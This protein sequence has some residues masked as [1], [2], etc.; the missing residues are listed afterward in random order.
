MRKPR[1][2]QAR[3]THKPPRRAAART[4]AQAEAIRRAVTASATE[5]LRALAPDESIPKVL[6]RIGRSADVSRVVVF[7]NS[8]AANGGVA[9][10]LCYEWDAA[11]VRPRK[12]GASSP[13]QMPLWDPEELIPLLTQGEPIRLVARQV[14]KPLRAMMQS[15]GVKS[16]LLVPIFVDTKWWG[17]ICFD[18]CRRERQWTAAE[19]DTLRTLAE[20]IGAAIARARD[21]RHLAD[22]SRVVEN[23]PVILFRIAAQSPYPLLYLSQNVSRFG[24]R[25]AEL[26]ASPCRYLDLFHPDDAPAMS[27]DIRRIL[28][29]DVPDVTQE[30]RLRRA[31]G[32]YA[33]VEARARLLTGPQHEAEI[34]G[35][36]IDIDLRWVNGVMAFLAA[37][38]FVVSAIHTVLLF[39][40]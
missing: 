6:E 29:G 32:R 18:D 31:D 33:W 15:A 24:Y 16:A 27:A 1:S 39:G 11:R 4:R 36:L 13:Q 3:L 7:R 21:L 14:R 10:E 30:R 38:N 34:E 2:A 28:N 17:H 19:A 25:A 12:A 37:A 9:A 26:M 35:I 20:M 40:G 8:P 5:L 23:S 22:A